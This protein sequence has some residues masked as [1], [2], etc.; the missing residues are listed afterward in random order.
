MASAQ[1]DPRKWLPRKPVVDVL[2]KWIENYN[3]NID[4][5]IEKNGSA[6]SG[7]RM[8]AIQYLSEKTG[9]ST[10]GINRIV[11]GPSE[12]ETEARNSTGEYIHI[13][14]ADK[15]FCAAGLVHHFHMLPLSAFYFHESVIDPEAWDAKEKERKKQ[16]ARDR[17]KKSAAEMR[18]LRERKYTK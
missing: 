14:N 10:R 11:K 18:E 2:N 1:R 16:L 8:T 9:I 3:K 6:Y 7:P 13:D 5:D 12:W 4:Y 15:L 17:A